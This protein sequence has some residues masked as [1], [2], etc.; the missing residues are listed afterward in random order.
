[1]C[2]HLEYA[3]TSGYH[4]SQGI[5]KLRFGRPM[6]NTQEIHKTIAKYSHYKWLNY[7]NK[8]KTI[9]LKIEVVTIQIT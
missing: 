9:I 1:M 6:L 5:R 7:V 3:P 8:I 2:Q 4:I